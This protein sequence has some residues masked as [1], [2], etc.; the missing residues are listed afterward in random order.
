MSDS[1]EKKLTPKPKMVSMM[2]KITEDKL[3][4]PTTWRF[5]CPKCFF[6]AGDSWMGICLRT[7]HH[8]LGIDVV[9][10]NGLFSFIM[11]DWIFTMI[12]ILYIPSKFVDFFYLGPHLVI[13]ALQAF[14]ATFELLHLSR[15]LLLFLLH[16]LTLMEELIF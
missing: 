11:S 13:L 8:L 14:N 4:G 2:S 5:C 7:I 12:A 1:E 10:N 3:T 9:G 15:L 6:L 16:L